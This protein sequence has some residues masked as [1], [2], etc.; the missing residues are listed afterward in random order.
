MAT[1]VVIYGLST[2]GYS[3]A[4]QIAL[5]GGDVQII[6]ESTPSAI[7]IKQDIAK[8]YPS[9]QALKDDEP[10]LAMTSI[11][12]AISKAQ[13]L[14][15]APRIRK[16]GQ[17]IKIEINSKFKDAVSNIKKGCNVV[18]GL[19]TGFGGNSENI[20]L[21][22]HVTGLKVG[23]NISYYYYPLSKEST[24]KPYIG[25]SDSKENETLKKLL[26][27]EKKFNFLSLNSAEYFHAIDILKQFSSQTSILEVCKF[28]KD[29]VTKSDLNSEKLGELYLDDFIDGLFDLRSLSSSFEGA[30]SLMYL[31]NG[32]MKGL[33]GYIK[34]LIDETRLI[35]KKNEL[36]ASRTKILLLW[37]LD[38]HEM[39]GEKIEKLLELETKLKDYIGDVESIS[40]PVDIFQNDKTTI[41]VVCSKCDFDYI[42][43]NN[44][45][46]E[47]IILKANPLCQ[48]ISQK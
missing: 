19:G 26:T 23:K 18:Y 28:A 6:D 5:N 21:L 3:L 44:K 30:S 9:V 39:K 32:S 16:T 2:E 17:D 22:E 43:K 12:A 46:D 45:D 15:F 48:L 42:M 1:K 38:Q 47:L 25:S 4:C 10:L 13:V 41:I 20:S 7:S 14:V 24:I 27:N 40:Q 29:S 8:S 36:K 33:D 34:R 37:T 31:I 11:D 35:L